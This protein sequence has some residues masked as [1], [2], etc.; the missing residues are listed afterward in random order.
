MDK[1]A[2]GMRLYI[3]NPA[4]APSR[5][6]TP[7]VSLE[8]VYF[9]LLPTVLFT[10]IRE[11]IHGTTYYILSM[12]ESSALQVAQ[13][14]PARANHPAPSSPNFEG[15]PG[16]DERGLWPASSWRSHWQACTWLWKF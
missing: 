14:V 7:R 8:A 12:R 11:R 16:S 9:K 15:T 4:G 2:N 5:H 1:G 13:F 3:S 10:T 6:A